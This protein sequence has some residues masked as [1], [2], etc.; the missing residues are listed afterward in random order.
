MVV[1][2]NTAKITLT[3]KKSDGKVVPSFCHL[4]VYGQCSTLVHVVDGVAVKVEGNPEAPHNQGRLCARGNAN[5]MELY[6]PYRVKVPLKRTNPEKGLDVDPKFVEISWE[7]ALEIVAEKLRAVKEEDSRQFHSSGGMADQGLARGEFQAFFGGA[8][9]QKFGGVAACGSSEHAVS[10]WA[11]NAH[12]S[13]YDPDYVELLALQGTNAGFG[14]WIGAAAGGGV[15]RIADARAERGARIVSIDPRCGEGSNKANEW[16]P[17]LP[18]TDLAFN[19]AVLHVILHELNRFDVE[20]IKLHTNGPYLIQSN[21]YYLKDA[22]GKPLVWDAAAQVARPFDAPEIKDFVLEGTYE[23]DGEACNP[24]FHLLKERMLPYTPEWAEQISTVPAAQIRRFAADFVKA[25]RIGTSIKIDGVEFPFRPAAMIGYHGSQRHYNGPFTTMSLRLI[26]AMVG[27]FDVPGGNKGWAREPLINY[28]TPAP[29]DGMLEF[30]PRS[31]IKFPPDPDLKQFYPLAVDT[32]IVWLNYIQT[33]P[34]MQERFKVPY[35]LKVLC[36]GGTNPFANQGDPHQTE[37]V[38][39]AIDFIFTIS[40]HIDD[41]A[42]FADVVLPEDCAAERLEA[43]QYSAM[44]QIGVEMMLLRQPVVP[45]LYDTKHPDEM[46]MELADKLGMLYGEDGYIDYMNSVLPRRGN[47][48]RLDINRKPTLEELVDTRLKAWGGEDKGLGW[49]SERG[50]LANK[51]PVEKDYHWAPLSGR[52]FPIY[53]EPVKELGDVLKSR[54]KEEYGWD[55]DTSWYDALPRWEPCPEH[56][57]ELWPPGFDLYLINYKTPYNTNSQTAGNPWLA[58]VY[59]ADPYF[60][61]AWMNE[62][63]G[64]RMGLRDGEKVWIES[65][66]NKVDARVKLS[67]TV[68]PRVVAIGGAQGSHATNPFAKKGISYA[69]LLP[70]QPEN[71]NPMLC[72]LEWCTRIKVTKA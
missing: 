53:F 15:S 61:R 38:M 20:F 19:L 43:R 23:V 45:R 13:G 56:R 9:M 3:E 51:L 57:D 2:S 49:F 65:T 10:A 27:N 47:P 31:A 68:H 40:I 6:D 39:R 28:D 30:I 66:V 58:E 29:S 18:G 11:H 25:A 48:V 64:K 8:P 50:L 41:P 60:L 35:T 34:E 44:F 69:S 7:E 32:H 63:T 70:Q 5:L 54:V 12:V 4:C 46:A 42:L 16:I 72:N 59:E 14:T 33:D 37:G 36:L 55:W 22:E 62:E 21:G 52:R 67:E 1:D 24:A 26:N 71:I 17:I